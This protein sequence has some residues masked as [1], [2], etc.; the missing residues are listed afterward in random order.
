M[1]SAVDSERGQDSVSQGPQWQIG[2]RQARSPVHVLQTVPLE[3]KVEVSR[4]AA[5]CC[6][7]TERPGHFTSPAGVFGSA[8]RRGSNRMRASTRSGC[9]AFTRVAAI[10]RGALATAVRST[11]TAG[12]RNPGRIHRGVFRRNEGAPGTAPLEYGA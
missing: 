3:M 8:A 12:C 5:A 4:E 10:H 9:H 1:M 2:S 7:S 6:R 11:A